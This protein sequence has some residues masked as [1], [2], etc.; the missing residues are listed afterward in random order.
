MNCL[1]CDAN[2][3]AKRKTAKYCSSTCRSK[4]NRKAEAAFYDDMPSHMK[5]GIEDGVWTLEDF[6]KCEC[7]EWLSMKDHTH[8][9]N[10]CPV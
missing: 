7:N 10:G 4:A 2:F 6:D 5:Q 3:D 1:S 8:L 9:F